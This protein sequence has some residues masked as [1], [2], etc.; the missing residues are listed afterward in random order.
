ME[1][2]CHIC[3]MS[4]SFTGQT[5][6]KWFYITYNITKKFIKCYL[7]HSFVLCTKLDMRTDS[8]PLQLFYK[9]L[10]SDKDS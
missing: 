5:L 9:F 7:V 8:P 10:R 3:H 4:Y 2:A 1:D 6:K